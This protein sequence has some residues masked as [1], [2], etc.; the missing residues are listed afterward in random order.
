[1]KSIVPAKS[2]KIHPTHS[3]KKTDDQI[4]LD[5]KNNNDNENVEQLQEWYKQKYPRG[6]PFIVACELGNL[7]DIKLFIAAH[8]EKATGVTVKELI[9]RAEKN[10]DGCFFTPLDIAKKN[11]HWNIVKYF[12]GTPINTY[13][14]P[15]II[16]RNQHMEEPTSIVSTRFETEGP[17]GI[18]FEEKG[19]KGVFVKKVVQNSLAAAC[20]EI[21]RSNCLL[22]INERDVSKASLADIML[23]LTSV[24]RPVVLTWWFLHKVTIHIK[25]N[26]ELIAGDARTDRLLSSMFGQNKVTAKMDALEEGFA[27]IHNYGIELG[28]LIKIGF[29]AVPVILIGM[30]VPYGYILVLVFLIAVCG[31]MWSIHAYGKSVEVIIM[32]QEQF[33]DRE[34]KD[35]KERGIMV[36]YFT[37][38]HSRVYYVN[39]DSGMVGQDT[40]R[41]ER[42]QR[43]VT[44]KIVLSFKPK[45]YDRKEMQRGIA[46]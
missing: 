24:G 41:E 40:R 26:G 2:F 31:F 30:Y 43:W 7:K 20:P 32:E 19:G 13:P 18:E 42:T 33:L 35:W 12:G 14:R 37:E 25:H 4:S 23:L 1:M 11:N 5:I 15:A 44:G 38:K 21:Q 16:W 29:V 17:L 46:L 3:K 9:N 27:N 34:L 45:A 36:G 22:K 10:S 39:V 28:T 8:D 6:T